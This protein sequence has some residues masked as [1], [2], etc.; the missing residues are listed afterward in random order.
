V[1][2]ELTYDAMVAF[3][4]EYFPAYSDFGQDP[5]TVQKMHEYYT[6]DLVFTGYTGF[7][8]PTVFP[9]RTAFL[10]FDVSHPS[11]YERLTVEDVTVDERRG[12]VFAIIKF[13]YVDRA[14]GAVLAEERGATQ[15]QLV[16]DQEGAIKIKSFVFFAQRLPAGALSGTDIFL[17]D[18]AVS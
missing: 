4:R 14:A 11:S 5:A 15:Y 18:R 1:T 3:M 13:E 16:L 2:V 12:V 7:A 6:P 10:E 17:R 8:E 9:D